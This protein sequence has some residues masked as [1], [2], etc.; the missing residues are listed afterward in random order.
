MSGDLND[1][2]LH[3]HRHPAEEFRLAAKA[4]AGGRLQ[5][6]DHRLLRDIRRLQS[7]AQ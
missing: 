2:M 4:L 7:G 5:D 3:D 6:V 1:L